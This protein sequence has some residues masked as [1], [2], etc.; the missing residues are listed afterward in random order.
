MK[1][2]VR[3][4]RFP[5]SRRFLFG[6]EADMTDFIILGGFALA[7]FLVAYERLNNRV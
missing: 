4:P 3:T 5:T 1:R 2:P 6:R 7:C